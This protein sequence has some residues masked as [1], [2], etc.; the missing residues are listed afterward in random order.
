M[1]STS[2]TGA[3]NS[4]TEITHISAKVKPPPWDT[5]EVKNARREMRTK[6]RLG[7]KKKNPS[8]RLETEVRETCI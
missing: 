7:Q 1:L 4:A 3:F 8:A 6:L 2:T 5:P